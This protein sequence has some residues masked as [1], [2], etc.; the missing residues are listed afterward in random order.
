MANPEIQSI[1]AKKQRFPKHVFLIILNEF[2]ERFSY[3]GIRT[4]LA[5]Y[6]TKF[7]GIDRDTTT[8]I[9]S[10]FTAIC[11]FTPVIGAIISD[12][13]L[14]KF[15][16]ILYL[17]I[18]YL[19]GEIILCLTSFKPLGA[20]NLAGPLVGLVIIGFGT[21]GI[22]P[23]VSAFGGDQFLG[24]QKKH[25]N[26]FFSVFYMSINLGSLISTLLTP[27]LR[28][29]VK[30]FGGHCYP[31]AF[32]VPVVVM[33]ISIIVFLIGKPLYYSKPLDKTQNVI[34]KLTKCIC[35]A[36]KKKF[37]TKNTIKKVH[38]LDYSEDEYEKQFINDAKQ[39]SKVVFM[40]LPLPI[41]WALFDQQVRI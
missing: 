36:L 5:L 33:L 41:F 38:W 24:D 37:F 22:K 21:G 7:I 3:Y 31:L 4:I 9:Y 35:F 27:Y 14:G 12:G 20:P 19:I 29:N 6:L 32:G 17:S 8:A 23:C 30:C 18:V 39:F 15:K 2:C 13:Y 11:Y 28:T 40:F 26:S 34:C 16:T 10:A 25:L 1:M